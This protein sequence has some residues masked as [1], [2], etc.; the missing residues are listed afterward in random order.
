MS[1][2]TPPSS[3]LLAFAG[4]ALLTLLSCTPLLTRFSSALPSDLGDPAL[5]TWILWWNAHAVPLTDAW[6]NAPMFAPAPNAF[7]LSEALLSLTVV[8]TPLIK[9][10][11]SPVAAYNTMFLL[12]GPLAA[13][14]AYLLAWQLTRR[15]SAAVIAALAFGF[16]PYRVA[17]LPHLQME[18]T[19]WLPLALYCL[20]RF[21][22]HSQRRWLV[23]LGACWLMSS[24]TN[25]YFL[26][27]LPVLVAMWIA[28]FVR[29]RRHLVQVLATLLLASLPVL[30]LLLAYRERQ[31]ALGLQ[32]GIDEI[33]SF[34][35]DAT[36][37]WAASTRLPVSRLWTLP[38]RPEGELYPGLVVVALVIIG[39]GLLARSARVLRSVQTAVNRRATGALLGAAVVSVALAAAV[40]LSGGWSFHLGPLAWTAH[41][42]SRFT[43]AA[44]WCLIV[45][46]LMTPAMRVA[47]Q[48]RSALA[49]YGLA[50]L[51]MFLMALGPSARVF[52]VTVLY[53]AP[54]SW[55]MLLPGGD[56]IRVPARF[57]EL[58]IL[59][60]GVSAALV[61]V[62]LVKPGRYAI[63]AV[64]ALAILC[65]GWIAL[66]VVTV[67][68]PLQVPAIA[69]NARVLELPMTLDYR[70][71]TRALLHGIAHEHPVVNGFSGYDPP[72]MAA[73]RYGLLAGD[74]SVIDTLRTSAPLAVFVDRTRDGFQ[75]DITRLRQSR[76]VV[77]LGNTGQ[78]TWF[79]WPPLVA[80]PRVVDPPV[81]GM[82]A[83]SRTNPASVSAMFDNNVRTRWGTGAAQTAGLS[84]ELSWNH[85]VTVSGIEMQLGP[86]VGDFPKGLEIWSVAADG[87]SRL[88]WSGATGGLAAAGALRAPLEVP[89]AIRFD[90]PMVSRMLRLTLSATDQVRYWSVAELRVLGR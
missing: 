3:A 33:Q 54:Y 31:H 79:T 2:D 14:G 82:T 11:A 36:A 32:R 77:E 19:C 4:C 87:S 28:W 55:L 44:F 1:R 70:A 51:V 52:G 74:L 34:S 29:E 88:A 81:T 46:G 48:R 67:P 42:A 65:E 80:Q 17:Q 27:F 39:L 9:L 35:A 5:N 64:A 83:V 62:R 8:T 38:P 61:W 49:F 30:P 15:R 10:G 56:S 60:L 76:D 58:M 90:Q 16:S 6:W 24:L 75:D 63:T 13:L 37:L 22:E 53:K 26:F 50:A 72:H 40:R 18:W 47:W 45:A 23:G 69:A 57:A 68:A 78:G 86:W 43:T 66:P 73:L 41:H 21:I 89:I 84:L 85:D 12:A 25:G 20:H 71:E 59:C 7:A